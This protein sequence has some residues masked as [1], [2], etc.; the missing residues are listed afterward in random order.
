MDGTLVTIEGIDKA[1]KTTVLNGIDEAFSNVCLT[2]EPYEEEW[3]GEWV[4]DVLQGRRDADE[5][6]TFSM[7]FADHINHVETC[8]GPALSAGKMVVCD[9]YIDSRYA[10]QQQ[11]LEQVTDDDTLDFLQRVNE[12]E[13]VSSITPDV[14]ILLDIPVEESLR[15]QNSS[16]DAE[17]FEERDFL[18]TVRQNYLQLAAQYDRF[19]VI[20]GAPTGESGAPLSTSASRQQVRENVIQAVREAQSR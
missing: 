7:F 9:R 17:R 16:E 8:V 3:T 2:S 13:Y 11:A 6:A 12:G 4:R 5:F 20:D 15:R 18:T 10:Y 14:T 19:V 1:G